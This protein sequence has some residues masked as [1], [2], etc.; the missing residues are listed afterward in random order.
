MPFILIFNLFT[1]AHIMSNHILE[2][3]K[4]DFVKYTV[5]MLLRKQQTTL[6]LMTVTIP[7]F[8]TDHLLAL[9]VQTFWDVTGLIPN[10]CTKCPLHGTW[11]GWRGKHRSIFTTNLTFMWLQEKGKLPFFTWLVQPLLQFLFQLPTHDTP[12]QPKKKC[13]KKKERKQFLIMAWGHRRGWF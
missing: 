11:N 2:V 9:K 12:A 7:F 13:K 1:T 3:S 4:Y 5:R 8:N 10:T 6:F